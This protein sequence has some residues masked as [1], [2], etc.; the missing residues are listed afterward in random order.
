MSTIIPF[1]ESVRTKLLKQNHNFIEEAKI[2]V[3]PF[4]TTL[5]VWVTAHCLCLHW[6]RWG[7]RGCDGNDQTTR[8]LTWWI[9]DIPVW[10]LQLLSVG[11]HFYGSRL[12]PS[13]CPPLLSSLL[14]PERFPNLQYSIIHSRSTLVMGGWQGGAYPMVS[15]QAYVRAANNRSLAHSLW[16]PLWHH[17]SRWHHI[18]LAQLIIMIQW[19][20]ASSFL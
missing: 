15:I 2:D 6:I 18:S 8:S 1:I 3:N 14:V 4:V 10:P 5:N 17:C 11:W 16:T 20:L 13:L 12:L 7:W 19:V 9:D